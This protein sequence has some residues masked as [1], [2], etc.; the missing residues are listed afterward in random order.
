MKQTTTLEPRPYLMA[1]KVQPYAWG[2]RG[3]DA[4]IPRLMGI[5]PLIGPA[6]AELWMGVHPKAP[7][8]VV[9]AGGSLVS[10]DQLIARHP[11]EILGQEVCDR[12][13]GTLPFLFKVLSAAQPLSIQVHPNAEQA[14]TLHAQRPEHYP[15]ATHKPEIAI[16]RDPLTPAAL[17]SLTVVR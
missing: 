13:S 16:A 8:D 12:F 17:R 3:K 7:S 5:E 2:G 15:D 1:N 14:Q 6:S 4:F 10:L 11:V 9:M